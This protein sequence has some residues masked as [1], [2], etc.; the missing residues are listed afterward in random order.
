MKKISKALKDLTLSAE[1]ARICDRSQPCWDLCDAL[2]EHWRY[3]LYARSPGP[4]MLENGVL[5]PTDLDLAC[6]LAAL[7]ERGAVINLPTYHSRRPKTVKTGEHVISNG[8]RHGKVL[9]LVSNREVFS[10]NVRIL[11]MNVMKTG[12]AGDSIGAE[13]NFMLLDIDGSWHEGWRSINFMP[14]AKENSFIAEH[15]LIPEGNTIVFKNFVHP[16]RSTSFYGQYYFATKALCQRI[17]EE[18]KHLRSQIKIFKEAGFIERK[19]PAEVKRE[20][21]AKEEVPAFECELDLPMTGSF[22]AITKDQLEWA[23]E[24]VRVYTYT[25]LPQL[26]FATRATELAFYQKG[27]KNAGFPAWIKGA[28]WESNYRLPKGRTDWERLVINQTFPGQTGFAL[29][30]RVYTKTEEV[31]V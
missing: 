27:C 7:A 3:D 15:K 12:E 4:A 28:K 18:L 25:V 8:N 1:M 24:V 2:I 29:R 26:R 23:Q 5:K 14:T 21:G 30:Y 11:D 9:G 10:F 31:A 6:F 19:P 20:K 13:R 22:P 16:N 17:D